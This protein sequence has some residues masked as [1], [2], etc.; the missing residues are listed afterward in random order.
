MSNW[1]DR[2]RTARG[3]LKLLGI[4]FL[5]AI[6]LAILALCLRGVFFERFVR[7]KYPPLADADRERCG[8]LAAEHVAPRRLEE[9]VRD[10][11][12]RDAVYGAWVQ[13]PELDPANRM[14][15]R[16]AEA[17]S[18]WLLDRLKRTL[19]AGSPAQRARATQW[20][21]LFPEACRDRVRELARFARARAGRRHETDLAQEA[22]A[23]LAA[24]GP[25]H[26]GT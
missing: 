14:A 25:P 11:R 16:L 13:E 26:D 3:Q 2:M 17:Q 15:R 4:T 21:S 12:G 19:V 20:L 1:H 23:V 22:D 24:L 18:D 9:L 6:G 7:E 5:G 8:E 10:L